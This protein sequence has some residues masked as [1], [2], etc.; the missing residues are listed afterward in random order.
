MNPPPLLVLDAWNTQPT[1]YRMAGADVSYTGAQIGSSFGT[2][3]TISAADTLDHGVCNAVIQIGSKIYAHALDEIW[4]YDE[5]NPSNDWTSI[6]TMP[7]NGSFT[8][9]KSG[10]YPFLVNGVVHIGGFTDWGDA[11]NVR[12]FR[13]NT[14]TDTATD[15]GLFSLLYSQHGWASTYLWFN[16]IWAGGP[17]ARIGWV[18]LINS[19]SSNV[20]A[21]NGY[22]TNSSSSSQQFAFQ[23]WNGDLYAAFVDNGLG[24]ADQANGAWTLQKYDRG[25]NV[26]QNVFRSSIGRATTTNAAYQRAKP[27]MWT[28]NGKLYLIFRGNP[29]FTTFPAADDRIYIYEFE[30][31]ATGLIATLTEWAD[32]PGSSEQFYVVMDQESNPGAEPDTYLYLK[33]AGDATGQLTVYQVEGT[34]LTAIDGPRGNTTI[35]IP[36]DKAGGSE[37]FWSA[38]EVSVQITSYAVDGSEHTFG[39]EIIG[40]ATDTYSFQLNY[41]TDGETPTNIATLSSPSGGTLGG[42]N[43]NT[44]SGLSAGVGY[45]V[46]WNPIDDGLNAFANARIVGR[47]F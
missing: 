8:W 6:Y 33:T 5:N 19:T 46:I 18:D 43:N 34:T 12:G 37:R 41:S 30:D 40:N 24:G 39:F 45:T 2:Q 9:A 32:P 44:L 11:L 13:I 10:L 29:T 38:N 25:L 47:V 17:Q 26:F 16:R 42:T 7:T 14:Q 35:Y 3:E 23:A 15:L 28:Q 21:E 22:H 31:S 27:A 36:R 20:T 4:M 1:V